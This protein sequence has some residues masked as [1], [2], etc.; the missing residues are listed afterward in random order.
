MQNNNAVSVGKV[1]AVF[2]TYRAPLHAG[3][4]NGGDCGSCI[5]YEERKVIILHMIGQMG[6]A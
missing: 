4:G 6:Y 1:T 2:E 5:A 3:R